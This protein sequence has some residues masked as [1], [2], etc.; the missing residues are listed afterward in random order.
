MGHTP[1]TRARELEKRRLKR[2]EWLEA[3]GPCVICGSR[4]RLEIDHKDPATKDPR[5]KSGT[6][7]WSW[8]QERRDAELQKCQVLCHRHHVQKHTGTYPHG[9]RQTYRNGC[10]CDACRSANAARM[11]AQRMRRWG[12]TSSK[13]PS[14]QSYGPRTKSPD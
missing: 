10:R 1:E 13:P 6:G 12:T 7:M 4:D 14:P 11:R 9:H 2:Q 5:L 8:T 3:H